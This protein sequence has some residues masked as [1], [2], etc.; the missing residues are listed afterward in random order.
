[1]I[2]DTNGDPISQAGDTIV[3]Q[4]FDA[5][6]PTKQLWAH[7]STSGDITIGGGD[8]NQITLAADDTNTGTAG[9]FRYAIRNT[10]DDSVIA[11][12]VLTI[13]SVPEV[14]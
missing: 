9:G 7:T 11:Q 10:T 12:G 1:V 2:V 14:S 6:D 13:V 8:N 3:F 4:A 5:A